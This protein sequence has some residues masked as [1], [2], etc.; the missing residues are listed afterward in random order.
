MKD[1]PSQ[2]V[3]FG[4]KPLFIEDYPIKNPFSSL[5]VPAIYTPPFTSEIFNCRV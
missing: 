2:F 1:F 3:D 4:L 5:I